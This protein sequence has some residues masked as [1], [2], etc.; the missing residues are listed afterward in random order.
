VAFQGAQ[1][2]DVLGPAEV[3]AS[4]ARLGAAPA[5]EVV[6]AAIGGGTVRATSGVGLSVVAL[7]RLRPRP[8]D[9]VLVVGGEAQA[10]RAAV[11]DAALVSWV[12]RAAR[13]ARRIGSV[14][15]GAFI[16]A[17]AGILDGKR[18]A[19]HWSAC[20]QLAAYRPAVRVDSDAIFVQD[21]R[22][23]TSAG[24]TTGID[25]ALA[26][27]E[28][29][30]GRRV[31]DTIAAR[32]VLYARRPGFQSQFSQ[33]LVAQSSAT[34]EL[35]RAV[36]WARENLR[37]QLDVVRL[38]RRAGMS[39][40]TLHRKCLEE[41]GATPAKVIERLRVE[42]ARTLLGTTRLGA[43]TIAARCGFGS[44]PRMACAFE[45]TLGVAPRDYRII[46]GAAP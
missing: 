10:I 30:V 39:I 40:R 12:A 35:S 14:C 13:V 9:T 22:C 32:L 34:D 31:A 42:Q 17:R 15:S 18:A 2:L 5:Y 46:S 36:S 41:M 21:G 6:V 25:M 20:A 44:A 29:D 4:V 3:F 38:A 8:N 37:A 28:E 11:H 23:W 33:A 19:T 1:G 45:R 26:M 43:K 16:L 7:E 27:V 24:V